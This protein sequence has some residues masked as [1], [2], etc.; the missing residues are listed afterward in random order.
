M[1][2]KEAIW[3]GEVISK[4]EPEHLFPMLN[5]GSSNQYFREQAQPW[6]NELVFQPAVNQGYKIIH[7]DLK[8]DVGVDLV[9]DL[10]D[11]N[12]IDLL[13]KQQ[14]KS[15]LCSNLLEHV[16]NK[17]QLCQIITAIIPEKGYLLITVPRDFPLHLDPIDTLFRPNVSELKAFFP[18]LTLVKGE[19]V[20]DG[21][22]CQVTAT[23]AFLYVLVMI[24]RLLCPIYQ[25]LRWLDSLRYSLWLFRNVSATCAVFKKP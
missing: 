18:D 8:S 23:P 16:N 13:N 11:P 17:E 20:V 5:L 15:I 4:L 2:R 25:P 21:L 22:L 24:L 7:T 1:L 12:F 19:I 10:N 3:L 9:G 6:I 14:V